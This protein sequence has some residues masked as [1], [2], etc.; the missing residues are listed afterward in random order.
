MQLPQINKSTAFHT[1]SIIYLITNVHNSTDQ[2]QKKNTISN[3]QRSQTFQ[4]S[5]IKKSTAFRTQSKIYTSTNVCRIL[6]SIGRGLCLSKEM[7]ANQYMCKKIKEVRF[8]QP[9]RNAQSIFCLDH[10]IYSKPPRRENESNHMH[11]PLEGNVGHFHW[12]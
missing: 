4:I 6:H 3:F 7:F 5:Q 10:F 2:R 11:P 12:K 9:H 8:Q 1:Q